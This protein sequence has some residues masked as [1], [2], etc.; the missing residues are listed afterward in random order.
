[1]L[2]GVILNSYNFK[3]LDNAWEAHKLRNRIA[4]EGMGYDVEYREAKKAI[5]LYESVFKEFDYI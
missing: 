1:M 4:H 3:T 2:N 5:E